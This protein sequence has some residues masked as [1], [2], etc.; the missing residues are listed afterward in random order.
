MPKRTGDPDPEEQDEEDDEDG[1]MKSVEYICGVIDE[2]VEAGVPVERVVVR[3]FSEGC[4]IS[5][6]VGLLSRYKDKLG[7]VLGLPGYRP[8]SGRVEK[9]IQVRRERTKHIAD[10]VVLGPLIERSV[11]SKEDVSEIQEQGQ[12]LGRREGGSEVV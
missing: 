10:E 3:G 8:L 9:T 6:L 12:R 5:P 11:G 2:E 4:A 1:M 7:G